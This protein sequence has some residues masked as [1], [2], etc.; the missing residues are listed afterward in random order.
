MTSKS[1]TQNCT[2]YQI[3]VTTYD[4]KVQEVSIKDPE[5]N[6]SIRITAKLESELNPKTLKSSGM[7]RIKIA[8]KNEDVFKELMTALTEEPTGDGILITG[9]TITCKTKSATRVI[10]DYSYM[11][12][13]YDSLNLTRKYSTKSKKKIKDSLIITMKGDGLAAVDGFDG[14]VTAMRNRS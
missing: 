7:Y 11:G 2:E 8:S 1:E 6:P 13:D 14:E 3:K 12:I 5:V 9:I 10:Y 4:G